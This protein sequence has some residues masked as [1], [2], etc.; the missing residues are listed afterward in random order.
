V[1]NAADE[2]KIAEGRKADKLR[3]EQRAADMCAVLKLPEGRRVLWG[4]LETAHLFDVGFDRNS[5]HATAFM[6]GERNIGNRLLMS[7][8][9]A[10]PN[11]I[12]DMMRHRQAQ[13]SEDS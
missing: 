5:S 1:S 6:Q 9:D 13:S 3:E 8:L 7:V 12:I 2:K 10:D 4:V 11:A